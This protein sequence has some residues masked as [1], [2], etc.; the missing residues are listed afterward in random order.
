VRQNRLGIDGAICN[1]ILHCPNLSFFNISD[2]SLRASSVVFCEKQATSVINLTTPAP[3]SVSA[4]L[5]AT[6]IDRDCI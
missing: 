1:Q 6:I 2:K 4:A 3:V 5:S